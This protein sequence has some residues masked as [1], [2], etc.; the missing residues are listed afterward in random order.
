MDTK[1]K[2]L[3]GVFFA[4]IV[5]ATVWKYYIFVTK[6]DFIVFNHASCNPGTESCFAY[7]CEINDEE[8]DQAPF[9]KISKNAENITDCTIGK[10]SEL[11]C[12][13]GE[14]DC[15]ITLCSEETIEEGEVCVYNPVSISSFV[16]DES[17]ATSSDQ[18]D[19]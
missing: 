9:K 7:N 4:L 18:T 19:L 15:V 3:I 13:P 11:S 14:T 12:G 1:S 10:C 16:S 2:I 5:T 17:S 8:C 6:Q